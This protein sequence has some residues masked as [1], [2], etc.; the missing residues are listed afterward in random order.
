MGLS[1]QCRKHCA[2]EQ[3]HGQSRVMGLP[4]GFD[5]A[6]TYEQLE[7]VLQPRNL[8][9][10]AATAV[11][12]SLLP[13][14]ILAQSL[15]AKAAKTTKPGWT[16][17]RTLDG[18]PDL[19]GVWANNSATPLERPKALAGRAFLTDEEVAALKKKA[20]ELF[21]NANSDAAFGDSVF[22]SVLAN[23]EGKKSGFKSVDGGTGDYSSVWLAARDWDN[24]TSLITDP[25]DGRLPSLTPE[26]ERK[27]AAAVAA[28]NRPPAGP[29]DR[30][31][32]ERCITYGS[33][34]LVAGYQS[35][36]Q[37]V[38]ASDSLAILTEM[39]HDVRV[40][41][42][43]GRPHLPSNIRTWLGDARGH[44]E[45]NTLVVDSTNYKPGVFR[46]ISTQRLHV[47]ERF[48]R[49][50]PDTLQWEVTIDDPGAW[51]RPWTAMIPLR[52]SKKAV[53]EYACHE[54]NYGLQDILAGAR[55]EEGTSEPRKNS[56]PK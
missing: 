7:V 35:Y 31:L 6:Y 46:N 21:G 56:Q 10:L 15:D 29:E 28:R 3:I 52:Y 2:I 54:G 19:Q 5:R 49:T 38:Q 50:G 42:L 9:F 34:Q 16:A 12:L 14:Q 55:R 37:I 45:G 22:D 27:V 53:F 8:T 26:A 25:P 20:A 18:Q 24:R 1:T 13:G 39:I 43:D 48:T 11:A 36:Y 47:I 41:P 17:P 51:T 44:W 40:I 33:P 4:N 23:V 32:S 30:S